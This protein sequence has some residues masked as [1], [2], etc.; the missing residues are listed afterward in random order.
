M[1][2]VRRVVLSTMPVDRAEVLGLFQN[3]EYLTSEDALTRQLCKEG[4]GKSYGRAIQ[5]LTELVQIGV[6]EHGEN[7]AKGYLYRPVEKFNAI[8]RK[9]IKPLDH[10]ADLVAEVVPGAE[11]GP[12]KPDGD[13]LIQNSP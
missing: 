12:V 10:I 2:L 3:P 11:D 9:S 5:L 13:P 6:L 7:T 1:E 8:I 4:I